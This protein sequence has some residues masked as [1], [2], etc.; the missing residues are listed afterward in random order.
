MCVSCF[1]TC[2]CIFCERMH[3]N[4]DNN[5][6][7]CANLNVYYGPLRRRIY[8]M[9]LYCTATETVCVYG[10]FFFIQ[11]FHTHEQLNIF[12]SY[13]NTHSNWPKVSEQWNR[14]H[15]SVRSISYWKVTTGNTVSRQYIADFNWISSS[16]FGRI[17]N[18]K[19]NSSS[20]S[21]ILACVYS[22]RIHNHSFSLVIL[23]K[24]FNRCLKRGAER[25]HHQ[26]E[27]E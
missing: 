9:L 23:T 20:V 12:V 10:I 2:L 18:A 14:L 1:W 11:L 16:D 8:Y 26:R 17:S 19:T 3:M 24:N 22:M 6:W 27:R 21:G 5:W 13:R 4:R 25:F 7:W 15:S